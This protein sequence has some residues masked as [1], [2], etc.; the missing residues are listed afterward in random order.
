MKSAW[1]VSWK[2]VG[3][4]LLIVFA[5]LGSAGLVALY[6]EPWYFAREISL[7]DPHLKTVPVSVIDKSVAKLTGPRIDRFEFSFQVPWT[8]VDTTKDLRMASVVTF[9]HGQGIL[10]FN[11]LNALSGVKLM[12]GTTSDQTEQMKRLLGARALSSDYDLMAATLAA[13]P[14]QVKWWAPRS[15]NVRIMVLLGHKS[16][17]MLD[18]GAVYKISS[19]EVRGFQFGNPAVAP[20]KVTLDLYDVNNRRYQ[21]M[22]TDHDPH[23]PFLS[24]GE[25]NAIVASFR[26]IPHS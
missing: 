16:M 21:I 6:M 22:I 15:E 26:P 17:E 11:P 19:D 12:K 4:A 20:Y 2:R 1:S 24:Q 8:D 10:V 25:V 7:D 23:G 14:A 3:I 13:T 18:F 5:V 9:K